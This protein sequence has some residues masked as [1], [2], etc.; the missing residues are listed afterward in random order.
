MVKDVKM[1]IKKDEKHRLR[2]HGNRA[3]YPTL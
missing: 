2:G 1:D 3:E